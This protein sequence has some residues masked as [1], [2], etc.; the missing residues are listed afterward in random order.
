MTV[1]ALNYTIFVFCFFIK[2]FLFC[3]ME[4]QGGSRDV[5]DQDAKHTF[6]LLFIPSHVFGFWNILGHV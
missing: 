3:K 6:N 5:K 1:A 4:K 2:N